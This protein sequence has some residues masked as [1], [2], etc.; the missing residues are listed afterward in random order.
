MDTDKSISA[1]NA[2]FNDAPH[3][4]PDYL[5]G[6]VI[7]GLNGKLFNTGKGSYEST[8]KS[9]EHDLNCDNWIN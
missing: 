4:E 3:K 6:K 8:Y 9:Q 5:S 7:D 1:N 2:G